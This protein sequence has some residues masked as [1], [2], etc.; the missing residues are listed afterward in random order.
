M[1]SNQY[2]IVEFYKWC[3]KCKYFK[4]EENADVCNECLTEPV[5]LYSR[6]PVNYDGPRPKGGENSK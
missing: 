2:H 6:I 4:L 1:E 5:N 3:E